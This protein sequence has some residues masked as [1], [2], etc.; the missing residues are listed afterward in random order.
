MSS[1]YKDAYK[2][3]VRAVDNWHVEK[4]STTLIKGSLT[5][6]RSQLTALLG[7]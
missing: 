1:N 5:L 6:I 7:R 4:Y 2:D 3:L